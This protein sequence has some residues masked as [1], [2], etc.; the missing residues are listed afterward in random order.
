[1]SRKTKINLQQIPKG[2]P[3]MTT[4]ALLVAGGLL[5]ASFSP[6]LAD[7]VTAG[8]IS[9]DSAE[10]TI[11][12]EDYS[13]FAAIPGT[14]AVPDIK[15]GDVITVDYSALDNGYD[16]INSITVIKDIAKRLNPNDKRG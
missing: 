12:L 1:M 4:R 7:S 3:I 10:R 15:S 13:Q 11:T 6:A 14:V 8:V 16:T 2:F 5:I 9:W